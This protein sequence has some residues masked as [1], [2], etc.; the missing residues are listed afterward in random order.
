MQAVK[1]FDRTKEFFICGTLLLPTIILMTE[2]ASQHGS[3]E[4]RL[5][6]FSRVQQRALS[7]AEIMK[8]YCFS[9][10]FTIMVLFTNYDTLEINLEP[11]ISFTM[12]LCQRSRGRHFA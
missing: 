2:I 1:L 6:A 8:V 3:V 9:L 5:G 12:N 10:I 7:V 4:L 11:D